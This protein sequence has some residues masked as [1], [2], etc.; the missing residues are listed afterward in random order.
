MLPYAKHNEYFKGMGDNMKKWY[1]WLVLALIFAVCGAINYFNGKGIAGAVIQVI[2]TSVLAVA[3]F[4]CDKKG[5]KG[6]KVFR[7]ICMAA[8]AVIVICLI[9]IIVG[10][11]K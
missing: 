1:W 2:I 4:L 8:I 11:F 6:K 5:E 9:Y 10:M 3:Q 7:Y